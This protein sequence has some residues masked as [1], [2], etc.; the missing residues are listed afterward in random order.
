[1]LKAQGV[2]IITKYLSDGNAKVR[3]AAVCALNVIALETKGKEDVVQY[4]I[5]ALAELL[6]SD[7]E[8]AYLHE[9]CVQLCRGASELP[10]FRFKFARQIIK[11]T[12]LLE[13]IYGTTALSAVSPLLG[14]E[15]T[16]EIRTQAANVTAHFLHQQK[17]SGGDT[18]RVPPSPTPD[19]IQDPT[20]YAM[21]ECTD[22]LHNLVG[23]LNIARKPALECL[24]V[25]TD[26]EKALKALQGLVADGKV[27]VPDAVKFEIDEMLQKE[28]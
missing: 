24:E 13:K 10:A 26:E 2:R 14:P 15:E 12:W 11:S 7:S 21:E 17:V 27:S 8:T 22:I 9:T 20:I 25:M 16:N 6:H 3:E 1:M 19:Q 18:I 28:V 4:S 5:E 23:L